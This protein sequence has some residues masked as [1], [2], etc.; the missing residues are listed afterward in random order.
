MP[1]LIIFTILAIT[2]Y[3]FYKIKSLRSKRPYEKHRV[4][5]KASIA[6]GMF[7]FFFGLNRLFIGPTTIIIIVCVI[8]LILGALYAFNGYKAFKYFRPLAIEEANNQKK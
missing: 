1:T 2:F 8:F 6:L 7:L 5:A 4:N 3:V